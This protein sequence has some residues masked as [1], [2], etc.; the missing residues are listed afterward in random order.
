[1]ALRIHQWCRYS[2]SPDVQTRHEKVYSCECTLVMRMFC[3]D[4]SS[5]Q[6]NIFAPYAFQYIVGVKGQLLD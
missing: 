5:I 3:A 6:N 2:F 1:M 4:N